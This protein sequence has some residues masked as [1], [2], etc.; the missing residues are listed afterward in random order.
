M[1]CPVYKKNNEGIKKIVLLF[2]YMTIK[3]FMSRVSII[4]Y[5]R[6]LSL[7]LSYAFMLSFVVYV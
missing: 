3:I 4:K 2:F 7:S 5:S 1:P 6:S